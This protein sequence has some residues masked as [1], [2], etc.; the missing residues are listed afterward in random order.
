[1]LL[2]SLLAADFAV[3][4]PARQKQG[5]AAKQAKAKLQQPA[6]P[7]P[8]DCLA[9]S[10]NSP[11]KVVEKCTEVI[12]ARGLSDGSAKHVQYRVMLAKAFAAQGKYTEAL[13][14][15]ESA[16]QVAQL[17]EGAE[18]LIERGII[19]N[20][21][22]NYSNAIMDFNEAIK[23]GAGKQ[24]SARAYFNLAISFEMI[25][26]PDAAR[27]QMLAG[28][29]M[30]PNLYADALREYKTFR[31]AQEDRKRMVQQ[32]FDRG[33]MELES[34]GY[35]RAVEMFQLAAS[36]DSTN[37]IYQSWIG[38]VYFEIKNFD[39]ALSYLQIPPPQDRWNYYMGR[40]F[41]ELGLY[42]EA[43]EAFKLAKTD[44]PPKNRGL[45]VSSD[46]AHYIAILNGYA[47]EYQLGVKASKDKKHDEALTHFNKALGFIQTEEVKNY[48]V[49]QKKLK[50]N[51]AV[52][53][54]NQK[55]KNIVLV[56]II[57][58]SGIF[59]NL[60]RNAAAARKRAAKQQRDQ[61]F[62]ELLDKNPREAKEAFLSFKESY[63]QQAPEL[64]SRLKE[65]M[66]KSGD[67]RLIREFADELQPDEIP[68]YMLVAVA[69]LN[70]PRQFQFS[71]DALGLLNLI[72]YEKWGE[73]EIA[74]FCAVHDVLD[75]VLLDPSNYVSQDVW[76]TSVPASAYLAL[77]N[78][79][80]ARKEHNKSV[81]ILEKNPKY[82]WED[83][84]WKV[85]LKCKTDVGQL[86]QV[87]IADVPESMRLGLMEEMFRKGFSHEV[88]EYLLNEPRYK[89]KPEYF[90]YSF[91]ITAQAKGPDDA[92]DVAR[93]LREVASPD[94][95]PQVYYIIAVMCEH[96]GRPE[97][98]AEIYQSMAALKVECMDAAARLAAISAGKA[99][100]PSPAQV[101]AQVLPKDYQYRKK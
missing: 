48:V 43:L 63:P 101:L 66:A 97:K 33:R 100:S 53:A 17:Q 52:A 94:K 10:L 11:A 27:K 46:T 55:T 98:A 67:V 73:K 39:K 60:M 24:I 6:G 30:A 3:A 28:R 69:A 8:E 74:A 80:L 70:A 83:D 1:M 99:P 2:A 89:W 23:L 34:K 84:Y 31:Q 77:S 85:Y 22:E 44:A 26:K 16:L 64:A 82:S 12:K 58:M 87:N 76:S 96:M 14:N 61:E 51:A 71:Q 38:S 56:L 72:P 90:F 7:T 20:K 37:L 88:S 42:G 68:D 93:Q 4:A 36:S 45:D 21:L 9:A 95:A 13:G 35:D 75:P 19:Q 78:M 81:Q 86:Q 62:L 54:R 59:L 47:E 18:P 29:V 25:G 79:Y 32:Y 41:M 65:N 91:A 49:S 92:L 15:I 40:C 57:V 5:S 50:A